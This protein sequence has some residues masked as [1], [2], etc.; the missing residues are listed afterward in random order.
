[1]SRN[2]LLKT[3]LVPISRI[4]KIGKP[5]ILKGSRNFLGLVSNSGHIGFGDMI[6]A[7]AAGEGRIPKRNCRQT[8]SKIFFMLSNNGDLDF[9]AKD[10]KYVALL[11]HKNHW[12]SRGMP[13]GVYSGPVFVLKSSISLS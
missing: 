2:L 9:P 11:N 4:P 12:V 3:V 5:A 7:K 10:R 13:T 1:M 8:I 6:L